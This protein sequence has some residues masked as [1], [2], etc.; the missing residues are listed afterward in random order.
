MP[1]LHYFIVCEANARDEQ[2]SEYNFLIKATMNPTS[3]FE[4]RGVCGLFTMILSVLHCSVVIYIAFYCIVF[5]LLYCIIFYCTVLCC[6]LSY[7]I[8]LYCIVLYS[9]VF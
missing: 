3:A 8:L 6:I 9:F 7:F 5:I 2:A 1:L 4:A